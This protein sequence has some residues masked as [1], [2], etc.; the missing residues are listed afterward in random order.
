MLSIVPSAE[1]LNAIRTFIS[2]VRHHAT[3]D[4]TDEMQTFVQEDFVQERSADQVKPSKLF[5][6]RKV[7]NK[8]KM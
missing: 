3:F 7:R 8:I 5:L 4:V 1:V 6:L 2:F